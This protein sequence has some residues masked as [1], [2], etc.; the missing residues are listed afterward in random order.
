MQTKRP[1]QKFVTKKIELTLNPPGLILEDNT[2]MKSPDIGK[3][4]SLDIE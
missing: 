4:Y 1:R 3:Q 2:P